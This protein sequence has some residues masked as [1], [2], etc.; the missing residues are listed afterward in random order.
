VAERYRA[1]GRREKGRMLDDLCA[2]TG[3]HRKH[4]L[5]ALSRGGSNSLAE[6][7]AARKRG[8]KYDDDAMKDALIT[9]R[10]FVRIR[11]GVSTLTKGARMTFESLISAP[12]TFFNGQLPAL[13]PARG[14]S[15]EHERG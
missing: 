1:A 6:E 2:T 11:D 8:R 12:E 15:Y 13:I 3:W 7:Q 10:A 14:E 9:L 5:R 4:A